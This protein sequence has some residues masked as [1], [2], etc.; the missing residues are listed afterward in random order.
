MT[1]NR[2]IERGEVKVCA[3]CWGMVWTPPADQLRGIVEAQ[4]IGES[5][6]H[7]DAVETPAAYFYLP[8]P[9]FAAAGEVC[10]NPA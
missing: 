3:S 10:D 4:D 1:Q 7:L 8:E 2:S 5:A 9:L 6:C